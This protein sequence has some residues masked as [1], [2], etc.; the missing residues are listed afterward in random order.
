MT[1]TAAA[2]VLSVASLLSP[3]LQT[4]AEEL[5]QGRFR[6]ALEA[7]AHEEDPL[8]RARQEADVFYAARDFASVLDACRRGVEAA[9]GDDPWLLWRAAG[10]ALWMREGRLAAGLS[11]RLLAAASSEVDPS[12]SEFW[13]AQARAFREQAEGFV[14]ADAARASAVTRARLTVSAWLVGLAAAALL[15]RR[16]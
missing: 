1:N 5:S 7:T 2:L 12:R 4:S 8:Q 15:W 3:S 14:K 13:S 9:G 6:A 10:A 11:E 16:S